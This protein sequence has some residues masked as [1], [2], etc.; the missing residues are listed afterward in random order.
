M[1][2]AILILLAVNTL[3]ILLVIAGIGVISNAVEQAAKDVLGF[4]FAITNQ[5]K[6][7]SNVPSTNPDQADG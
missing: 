6:E 1:T 5:A 7:A 2:L 3:L 4:L